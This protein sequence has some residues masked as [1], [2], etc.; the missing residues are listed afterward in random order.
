MSVR[1][2]KGRSLVTALL[3]MVVLLA[4]GSAVSYAKGFVIGYANGWI[5]N[6]WRAQFLND[7]EEKAAYYQE[8]GILERINIVN[9][10]A[11][12]TQQINQ[13]NGLIS[14]RPDALLIDPVSA[15][16]V[17]PLVNR[18][19]ASGILTIISNDPAPT[20]NA[21]NIVGDN[22]T[23]WKIQTEWLVQK[24]NGR[25]KIVMITGVPGNT[26]DILRV[27]A[28][29]D[30]LANYPEIEVVAQAAGWWDQA[31]AQTAMANILASHPEID[32]L[33]IQDVMAEGVIR[34][35]Q[36][37]G[38]KIPV[39]T[40][41]YTAGFLRLWA[42]MPELESI[43]V[44]YAPAHGADS[45]GFAVRLL[46]GRQ[47]R[48]EFFQPNPLDP[49]LKNTIMIP[50]PY[51]VTRDGDKDAPWCSAITQCISLEEALKLVEGQPDTYALDKI[52]TEE[53]ID[54]F[55]H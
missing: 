54:S 29:Q 36:A 10:P 15:P 40:G 33:L 2:S 46:Q 23:W 1:Y 7:I 21:I 45:L 52:M 31:R 24:L 9:S 38:R 5:G 53:E 34:A 51:V 27:Q 42:S 37:A 49:S 4:L 11:D 13:I 3:V 25:G 26:A 43:G 48:E 39:M 12:L 20:P 8:Q 14:Q 17:L 30:V 22:Y 50:V 35:F 18:A 55:F 32:G 19:V 41:D 28:A 44:P 16:G 6:T 47:I